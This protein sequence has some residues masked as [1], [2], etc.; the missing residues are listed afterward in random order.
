MNYLRCI[1]ETVLYMGILVAAWVLLGK[2][3][4]FSHRLTTLLPTG[5]SQRCC[6]DQNC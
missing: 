4:L 3:V 5:S 1:E 2:T 6:H